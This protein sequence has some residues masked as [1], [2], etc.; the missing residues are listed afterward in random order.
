LGASLGQNL[1]RNLSG[2]SG[3]RKGHLGRFIRHAVTLLHQ[4]IAT[5]TIGRQ[6]MSTSLGILSQYIFY[7]FGMSQ[8]QRIGILTIFIGLRSA[9][10]LHHGS[11]GSIQNQ[12]TL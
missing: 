1:I 8:I 4:G 5:K 7:P 6:D 3:G 11:H 9:T 2:N 12:D 10:R